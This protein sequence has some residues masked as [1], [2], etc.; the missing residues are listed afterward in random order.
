M[1]KNTYH[2]TAGTKVS[3]WPDVVTIHVL[4]PFLFIILLGVVLALVFIFRSMPSLPVHLSP[5]PV[6]FPSSCPQFVP[7]CSV[8]PPS[9]FPT[10]AALLTSL[11]R[12][13]V[14]TLP[15]YVRAAR[16]IMAVG[17]YSLHEF[18]YDL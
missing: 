6:L 15:L 13:I 10:P 7:P 12:Q 4:S 5:R 9:P 2:Y 11:C 3:C 8:R 1:V 18:V 17:V 16:T 14:P